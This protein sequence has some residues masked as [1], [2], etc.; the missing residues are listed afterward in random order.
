MTLIKSEVTNILREERYLTKTLDGF[1]IEKNIYTKISRY[2]RKTFISLY[3]V[4]EVIQI[5]ERYNNVINELSLIIRNYVQ[6]YD[7]D[8]NSVFNAHIVLENTESIN[9]YLKYRCTLKPLEHINI[10]ISL[11]PLYYIPERIKLDSKRCNTSTDFKKEYLKDMNEK[12][13]VIK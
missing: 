11:I 13:E 7:L 5:L 4:F 12:Y 8:F 2:L 3:E 10:I 6:Y 1:Y 9:T